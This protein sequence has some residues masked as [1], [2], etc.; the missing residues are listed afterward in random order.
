MSL[1]IGA[2]LLLL[3]LAA[4]PLSNS[5]DPGTERA[6]GLLIGAPLL[7]ATAGAIVRHS[8]DKGRDWFRTAVLGMAAGAVAS[9]LFIAAQL[10]T[11]PNIL[12]STDARRLL[13]FVV[14]VGFVA[15]LTFDDVYRKLRAEDVTRSNVL[16][17]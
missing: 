14:P 6:L 17:Q 10:L 4:I 8:F 9:L 2:V 11:T 3:A 5:W 7:A 13:F 15:G 12:E 1:L 16:Q